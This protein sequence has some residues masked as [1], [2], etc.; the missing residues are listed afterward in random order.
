VES[1]TR[2]ARF[3]R[4][5]VCRKASCGLIILLRTIEGKLISHHETPSPWLADSARRSYAGAGRSFHTRTR[6]TSNTSTGIRVVAE[7]IGAPAR[8]LS[9]FFEVSAMDA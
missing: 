2:I 6:F 3:G 7:D 4:T 8:R 5:C 9:E 1:G